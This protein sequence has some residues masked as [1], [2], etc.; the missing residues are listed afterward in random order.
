MTTH[1][2]VNQKTFTSHKYEFYKAFGALF[3][4][5]GWSLGHQNNSP[6]PPNTKID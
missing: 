2:T 1:F 3:C 5:F 6:W 4:G